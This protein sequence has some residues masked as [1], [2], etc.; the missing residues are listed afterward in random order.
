MSRLATRPACILGVGLV[1]A[2]LVGASVA[3]AAT[4]DVYPG[5]SIATAVA[6]SAPGDTVVVHAGS[7]PRQTM[8]AAK[9]EPRVNIV[10]APG[11]APPTVAG[12][13]FNSG[14]GGVNIDGLVFQAGSSSSSSPQVVQF[15]RGARRVRI[16]NGRLVGGSFALK[17]AGASTYAP[18]T[19]A[20]DVEVVNNEIAGSYIDTVQLDGAVNF[21]F[22][23]NRI[24]DP[25]FGTSHND[26]IQ[27]IATRGLVIRANR[28][29]STTVHTLGPH[30]GMMLGHADDT[31][32]AHRTVE[33]TTVAANLIYGWPG[34]GLALAGTRR[35]RI[36]NNSA[37][38]SG[39]AGTDCAIGFWTKSKDTA[40]YNNYNVTFA[41]NVTD[42]LCR[43]A[44]HAAFDVNTHNAVETGTQY[45]GANLITGDVD[46]MVDKAGEYR[47]RSGTPLVDSANPAYAPAV[48]IDGIGPLN[49]RGAF[50]T[51]TQS[52]PRDQD[53]DGVSDSA[54]NCPTAPNVGQQD[55]DGD[56]L[57][58]ACDLVDDRPAP[59]ATF[60][61]TP[62][63]SS[64]GQQVTFDW[65]GTCS[66]APCQ[67][68]WVDEG[69]DGNG[70]ASWPLGSGDPLRFTFSGTGIKYIELTVRDA[71][72]RATVSP[73]YQHTVRR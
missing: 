18:D 8:P 38:D 25:K 65:T 16:A 7:Y 21:T 14:T 62:V 40:Y 43:S 54:D 57:G 41:D 23:H 3:D 71:R 34:T 45:G 10:A 59:T 73:I 68:T 55:F 37:L 35:S 30:Q 64:P 19:W 20:R 15:T 72:G 24:H 50:E 11:E 42:R 61:A 32:R 2:L 9:A 17:A 49:D 6:A 22:E 36:V 69:P 53:G 12:M 51:N 44:N 47:T 70:G 39:G 5:Q 29:Y 33:D 52:P 26:G 4:R 27:A 58:D 13:Q 67:V 63:V 1:G 66:V 56:G 48:D 31:I 46:A 28:F 60:T